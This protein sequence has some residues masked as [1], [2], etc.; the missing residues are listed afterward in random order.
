MQT[1]RRPS[2]VGRPL[3]PWDRIP[4]GIR[5]AFISTPLLFLVFLI[6]SAGFVGFIATGT[7]AWLVFYPIQIL[8]YILN[9]V[10]SAAQARNSHSKAT[11]VV[12]HLHE[13]VQTR[14]PNY[15]AQGALGGFV[16][17]S[18]GL[19]ICLT[20]GTAA[21]ILIPLMG[22]LFTYA[23]TPLVLLLAVDFAVAI[24]SGMLGAQIFKNFLA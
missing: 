9:G 17:A 12:G 4:G 10:I 5:G 16:L 2:R 15:I 8:A 11:R 20:A 19:V 23:S 18:I 3:G 13:R 24:G 22:L 21:E 1:R 6:N 7:P 14:H